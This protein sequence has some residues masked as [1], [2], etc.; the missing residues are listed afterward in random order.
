MTGSDLDRLVEAITVDCYDE[1]EQMAAFHSVFSD[2]V[3]L[4][5][6]TALLGIAVE[7]LGFDLRENGR[8]L[9]ALCRRPG[10]VEQQVS[11]AD[12]VF[13][14]DSVVGRLHAAYRRC[15]GLTPFEAS[16]PPGWKPSW[17]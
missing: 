6:P 5:T 8:E 17:L 3:A 16:I 15:L 13:P 10:S 9:V 14:P 4:P 7:V 1:E 11:L 12:L 2:E